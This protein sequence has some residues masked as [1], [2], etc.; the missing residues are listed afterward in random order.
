[1]RV[2]A[3]MGRCWVFYVHRGQ[4]GRITCLVRRL[5]G[6]NLLLRIGNLLGTARA[7]RA[8]LSLFGLT[9]FASTIGESPVLV[10]IVK[11]LVACGNG[12]VEVPKDAALGSLAT[13]IYSL[14][15]ACTLGSIKMRLSGAFLMRRRGR[16]IQRHVQTVYPD[17]VAQPASWCRALVFVG[18]S[19]FF[20][21][22]G[23]CCRFPDH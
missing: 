6:M 21:A 4:V 13:S 1:M 8:G 11:E 10:A 17:G 5:L 18:V 2:A 20:F 7:T 19:S 3:Q 9:Q 12:D 23:W 15:E 22:E 14:K 16:S